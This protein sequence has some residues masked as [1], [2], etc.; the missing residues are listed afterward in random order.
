MGAEPAAIAVGDR[1]VWVAMQSAGTVVRIEPRSGA[2]VA[3]IG[4]GNQPS[5]IAVGHAAV[6]VANRQD[7]TVSRI[8]PATDA[9]T[10]S[11]L[12]APSPPPLRWP[13][14]ACGSVARATARWRASTPQPSDPRPDRPP[15]RPARDGRDG[16]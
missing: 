12:S 8:D 7:N 6:W 5:A 4:V 1:A 14:M 15:Q 10:E 2:V 11:C 9:V 3:A 16:A 13:P